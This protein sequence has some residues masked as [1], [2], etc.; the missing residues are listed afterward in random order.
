[1][2]NIILTA[3][4]AVFCLWFVGVIV[5]FIGYNAKLSIQKKTNMEEMQAQ[6][7]CL[8]EAGKY[9]ELYEYV[10]DHDLYDETD[11]KYK[12]VMLRVY[13]YDWF[14]D[15]AERYL[16]TK[17]QPQEY[18]Y[19][20][21][22]VEYVLY[23]ADFLYKDNVQN[24]EATPENQKIFAEWT[25]ETDTF[26]KTYLYMTEEEIEALKNRTLYDMED[27]AEQDAFISLLEERIDAQEK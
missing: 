1:M 15:A 17:E 25:L 7:E 8:Y 14:W 13:K 10:Y 12:Q 20:E 16:E 19:R 5:F 18:A 26:L 6:M 11:E 21:D 3:V 23:Y 4:I 9:N 27:E 24:E 2:M 22:T